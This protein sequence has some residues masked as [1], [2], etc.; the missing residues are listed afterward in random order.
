MTS[1]LIAERIIYYFNET[2]PDESILDF[3]RKGKSIFHCFHFGATK[4]G[5]L[6]W[7]N[8]SKFLGTSSQLESF[9]IKYYFSKTSNFIYLKA[10]CK[11]TRNN[12]RH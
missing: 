8:C 9:L 5:Y 10:I 11:Y 7:K 2:H 6:Y 4:E 3:I 1:E 12:W